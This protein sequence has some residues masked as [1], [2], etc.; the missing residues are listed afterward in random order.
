MSALDTVLPM[1]RLL[2]IDHVDLA[3]PAARAW[4]ILRNT[5]LAHHALLVRALFAIR[6]LPDRL[7]GTAKGP[8]ALRISDLTSSI[9]APGFQV[10]SEHPGREVVVGAIGKVWHLEIPFVHVGSAEAFTAFATPGFAK[11][12]WAL[13]VVPLG[14]QECKVEIE[15]RVDATDEDAWG[16]F[17]R[18]FVLIGPGSRFI[19]HSLL[20]G[21][22]REYGTPDAKENERPLPGDELLPDAT[23]QVSLAIDVHAPPSALWPWIVQM[24]GQRAGFYSIDLLDN[25]NVRSAR[26]LHPE[27]AKLK[28]GDVIPATRSSADGF[29]VLRIAEERELVLG[30]LFDPE[31]KTQLRFDAPRP[32][33]FWQITWSFVLE[34]RGDGTTRLHTR[35]RARYASSGAS[36]AAWIRPVHWLM[37][38]VQ[39]RALAARAEGRLPRDDWRD[40]TEGAGGALVMAAAFLT[41]FMRQARRHWGLDEATASRALPG[42]E[43]SR[44]PTGTGPTASRSTLRRRKCG[45]G[46]RRSARTAAAST[47]TSG[48]RTW[49]DARSRT[50]SACTRS[51]RWGRT[52]PSRCTRR[53]RRSRWCATRPAA[54]SSCT[55]RPTRPRGASVPASLG[56]RPAGA[57]TWSRSGRTAAGSSAAF[58]ARP[59][60]TRS[61]TSSTVRC[62]WSP[63]GSPWTAGCCSA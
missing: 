21:L 22:A 12:A 60:R 5:D 35:A 51:W 58:A 1:P 43:L 46:S 2:E 25:E 38:S 8:V 18:Y 16:K 48:S 10:L 34:P 15:V 42:D 61:P 41:P 57:S 26:E 44:S 40:V 50:P 59:R 47:A 4:D 6:T 13:R 3:I 63:S 30:G 32:L 14:E 19:R 53:C 55:R 45:R 36:H 11:V 28:V 33:H 27:L 62:S 17:R 39:L 23:D 54:T 49:P 31:L 56:W 29:E 7:D 24:G 52:T 37:Q 9:S 20:S